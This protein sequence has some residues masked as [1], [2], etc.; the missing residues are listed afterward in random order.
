VTV[1]HLKAKGPGLSGRDPSDVAG[2]PGLTGQV[3]P[4]GNVLV[5]F[6]IIVERA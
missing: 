4:V 2:N 1:R 3:P 5:V 6:A